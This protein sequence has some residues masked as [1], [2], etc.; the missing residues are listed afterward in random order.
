[1]KKTQ[2]EQRLLYVVFW[3]LFFLSVGETRK[4]RR[5]QGWKNSPKGTIDYCRTVWTWSAR[6]CEKGVCSQTNGRIASLFAPVVADAACL[7]SDR[8]RLAQ[9]GTLAALDWLT[10]ATITSRCRHT[11][12]H[13]NHTKRPPRQQHDLVTQYTTT[14]S[15]VHCHAS[16]GG[17][18]RL[19]GLSLWL[20]FYQI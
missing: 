8:F 6:P 7:S 12:I 10:T 2:E 3:Y 4:T 19:L 11:G 13:R 14:T 17:G 18:K 20:S 5:L 9:F 1:M 15:V 16:W